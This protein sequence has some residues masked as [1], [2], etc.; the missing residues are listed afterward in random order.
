MLQTDWK[1]H[2]FAF[3]CVILFFTARILTSC[4]SKPIVVDFA[5][6]GNHP[7]ELVAVKG[8]LGENITLREILNQGLPQDT[9]I[10]FFNFYADCKKTSPPVV[11]VFEKGDPYVDEEGFIT[12]I[13]RIKVTASGMVFVHIND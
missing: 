3:G 12:F 13:G 4:V 6:I 8:C 9:K 11:L 2:G 1:M 5:E 7:G 10:R